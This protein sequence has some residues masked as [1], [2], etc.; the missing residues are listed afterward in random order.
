MLTVMHKNKIIIRNNYLCVDL[1]WCDTQ[2]KLVHCIVS[3]F[4]IAC[5]SWLSPLFIV[6]VP[7]LG[8]AV[9]QIVELFRNLWNSNPL[10]APVP[11]F[12]ELFHIFGTLFRKSWSCSVSAPVP[13]FGE[14]FHIF[15]T[16][17]HNLW[18]C[19]TK[20]GTVPLC[21]GLLGYC[22]T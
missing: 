11:L 9:P 4:E 15:R 21:V 6:P 3:Y 2:L 19:S 22:R 16:L 17:F 14:L 7:L 10:S 12:G 20:S 13:L 8:R 18:N 5:Y 1:L